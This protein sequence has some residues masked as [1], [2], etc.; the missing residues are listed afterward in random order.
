MFSTMTTCTVD[1]NLT[2]NPQGEL[3]CKGQGALDR[4]T[5][6]NEYLPNIVLGDEQLTLSYGRNLWV[7]LDMLDRVSLSVN[8]GY[9]YSGL[10]FAPLK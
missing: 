8:N 2:H 4:T 3:L 7:S 10:L 9:V 1:G 5:N 6:P